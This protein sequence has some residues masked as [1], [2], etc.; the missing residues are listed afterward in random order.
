MTQGEGCKRPA[1]SELNEAASDRSLLG[2][3][4]DGKPDAATQLYRRYAARLRAL[5]RSRFSAG[6]ARRVDAD[7]IIQSVFVTFFHKAQRGSYDVPAGED[8]WKLLLVIAMNK[9]R[10]R[11]A[12]HQAAK[13]DTRLTMDVD[14]LAPSQRIQPERDD[15]PFTFMQLCVQEAFEHLS[16]AH[17]RVMELRLEGY[18]VAEI[19]RQ[20]GR[21]KRTVE[22]I[23][24]EARDQLGTILDESE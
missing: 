21:S 3:L 22:R 18:E 24:K 13:R 7:D 10:A 23:L 9:I 1:L 4:R 8:L 19:A 6:L 11:A 20:T 12:F 17:R 16:P 14:F 5:A 2:H 15:F